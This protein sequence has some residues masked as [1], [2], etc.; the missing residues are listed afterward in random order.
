MRVKTCLYFIRCYIAIGDG[1]LYFLE[2]KY[3]C[4]EIMTEAL[5]TYLTL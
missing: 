5:G 4:A 3:N 2:G 1:K